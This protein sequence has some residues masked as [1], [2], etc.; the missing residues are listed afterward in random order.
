M[1][2]RAYRE[3]DLAAIE[4]MH[5]ESGLPANC[6]PVLTN[7][8]FKVK[9]VA[10]Q[11]GKVVQAGFVKL[12]GE[13]FILVDHTHATPQERLDALEELVVHG[14][15][16]A[17]KVGLDDVSAWLPPE[18][19]RAFGPRLKALGFRESPWKSYSALLR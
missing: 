16:D 6:L 12:T 10:D 2:I 18:V 15:A 17:A 4:R 7:P 3:D 8:L 14:L 11:Q 5:R 13:A 9:I 1:R 19:E